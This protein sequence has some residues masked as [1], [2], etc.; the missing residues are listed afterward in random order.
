LSN[1]RVSTLNFELSFN[2]KFLFIAMPTPTEPFAPIALPLAINK[3]FELSLYLL[4]LMGFGALAATGGL[5]LPTIILVGSALAFR[6]YLLTQRRSIVIPDRWSTPLTIAYFIFYAADFF[7]LSRSF[8]TATVHLVLFA[9][10]VRTFSLRRDRDYT[11]LAILAFLMLLASAVLTVDSVFLIFFGGFMLTAVATFILMEMRQSGK[12]ASFRARHSSDAQEHRHLAFSLGRM[13]L[14]L[15]LLIMVGAAAM[16]FLLPR[17]SAGYL[18]NYS[19][20]NDFSTGFSDRVQLGGIGQIQQ[21]NAVAMHLQIDGDTQG[22][23]DLHWRGMA[24]TNFNGRVWSNVAQR[25][26]LQR[27]PNGSFAVPQF[28]QGAPAQPVLARNQTT[29]ATPARLIHYRVVMEPIGTSVFFLAPWAR[30]VRGTYRAVQIDAGGGVYDSDGERPPSI[31]DAVSDIST[32]APEQLRESGDYL[33]QFAF[34]YLQLPPLDSRIPR[35]AQQIS[36]SAGNNNNYDK[37]A[38]IES[39]LKTH[40]GYTLQLP[41]SPVADPLANFLFERRQGH[42][43]YFASAMAVMLRTQRIPARVVNGFRGGEFNDLT[44][45]YVLRARDAHAWVEAYFPGYG[46]VTFDPTPAANTGTPQGWSRLL[47]YFDAASS[48]WREWVISYDSSHQY[49]LGQTALSSTRSSWERAQSWGRMH[50]ARIE[51]WARRSERKVEYSPLRWLGIAGAVLVLLVLLANGAWIVQKISTR[52][53]LAH[54]ERWPDQAAAIWYERMAHLLKR[55]GVQKST[56]Q[57]A[58]EF[59]QIITEEPLRKRVGD[60]TQAYESAR[61]GSSAEDARRLPELYDEV[62]LATRK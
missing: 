47:L 33:P 39:Y 50:Y 58:Q 6:G 4:V 52:R 44:G 45:S 28:S 16:F 8:L 40:Y 38:A 11:M 22:R 24:L 57:T 10:V 61:F 34:T 9:V 13:T 14:I 37:A 2:P 21:S 17:M 15:V 59:V 41:R 49:V 56:S 62:E 19:F 46:W 26:G 7:L 54:P 43:E 20:G 48:F 12:A 1:N 53:L 42:C 5:D 25:S 60:F 32:P 55:R 51:E 35:L 29:P 3:Y 31:Y 23:Y 30:R 27:E 36:A 18:G